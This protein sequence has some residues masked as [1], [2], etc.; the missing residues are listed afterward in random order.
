MTPVS[1][2][3]MPF[4]VDSLILSHQRRKHQRGI[5]GLASVQHSKHILSVGL[6]YTQVVSNKSR[7][8]VQIKA[9]IIFRSDLTQ[10]SY[11]G[12][13]SA[14]D[15]S[16]SRGIVGRVEILVDAQLLT[17]KVITLALKLYL[18]LDHKT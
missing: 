16:F 3:V 18:F 1:L 12:C 14:F 13:V 11:N 10:V 6:M 8:Q 17:N 4:G 2:Q 15:S 9:L 5:H 7:R